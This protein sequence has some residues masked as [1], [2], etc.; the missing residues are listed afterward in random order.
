MGVWRRGLVAAG[1]PALSDP[2]GAR[3]R[4]CGGGARV[5]RGAEGLCGGRIF[6]ADGEV[7]GRVARRRDTVCGDGLRGGFAHEIGL[8]AQCEAV[9]ARHAAGGGGGVAHGGRRLGFDRGAARAGQGRRYR[10]GERGA[11][12]LDAAAL[13]DFG[14]GLAAA[15]AAADG[16]DRGRVSRAAGA[17]VEGGLADGRRAVSE[18]GGAGGRRRGVARRGGAHRTG[19]R[20][21]RARGGEGGPADARGDLG[22]GA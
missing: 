21:D 10:S 22:R 17:L 18:R 1:E 11:D 3:R 12:L 4:R 5:R 19:G 6:P 9:D 7:A 2:P 16:A 15:R 20:A 14:R 13:S 8:S